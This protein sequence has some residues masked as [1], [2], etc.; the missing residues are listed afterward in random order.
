MRIRL[1]HVRNRDDLMLVF[2]KLDAI[3]EMVGVNQFRNCNIYITPVDDLGD[4]LTV[5][6]GDLVIK[7]IH[8]SPTHYSFNKPPEPDLMDELLPKNTSQSPSTTTSAAHKAPRML[9]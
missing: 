1:H 7:E 2:C 9:H 4:E 6:T 8:I 3:L 5:S